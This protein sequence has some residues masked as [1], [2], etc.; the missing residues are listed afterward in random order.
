VSCK[1]EKCCA[2]ETECWPGVSGY[3]SS[4][5]DGEDDVIAGGT[6]WRKHRGGSIRGQARF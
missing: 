1:G 3:D 4:A 5:G 6:A 2:A